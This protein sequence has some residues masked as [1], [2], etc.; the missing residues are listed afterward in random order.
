MVKDKRVV[1]F[2]ALFAFMIVAFF[3]G[4]QTL[5]SGFP[6]FYGFA[7]DSDANVYVGRDSWI[8]VYQGDR[9]I[10]K[11]SAQTSRGYTFALENNEILLYNGVSYYCMDLQGEV[12]ERMEEV[13]LDTRSQLRNPNTRFTAA[14][15]TRYHM[16]G[17]LLHGKRI[18]NLETGEVVWQQRTAEV[19]TTRVAAVS[20]LCALFSG[21]MAFVVHGNPDNRT[22]AVKRRQERV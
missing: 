2:L 21:A 22:R 8:H 4:M 12:L 1:W 13:D 3:T 19:I 15:S 9:E 17:S 11:L 10:R 20:V 5:V 16:T 7:V 14:D 18:W 6:A